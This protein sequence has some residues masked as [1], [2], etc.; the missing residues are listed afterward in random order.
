MNKIQVKSQFYQSQ[1]PIKKVSQRPQDSMIKEIILDSRP[2]QNQLPDICFCLAKYIVQHPSC[3]TVDYDQWLLRLMNGCSYKNVIRIIFRDPAIK[4][5]YNHL[6]LE[7]VFAP[8]YMTGLHL[9]QVDFR[10]RAVGKY[11]CFHVWAR[12]S[13]LPQRRHFSFDLPPEIQL[14][15][16]EYEI[17]DAEC[18]HFYNNSDEIIDESDYDS[19]LLRLANVKQKFQELREMKSKFPQLLAQTP[20]NRSTIRLMDEMTPPGTMERLL[21]APNWQ[22]WRDL[23]Q[24]LTTQR[25]CY[26]ASKESLAAS[27]LFSLN[28][29]LSQTSTRSDDT[30]DFKFR[31]YSGY[32]EVTPIHAVYQQPLE[33]MYELNFLKPEYVY[34][35]GDGT[36]LLTSA[37]CDEIDER[38]V[39]GRFLCRCH[40]NGILHFRGIMDAVFD[41]CQ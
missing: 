23:N 26:E 31:S 24:I 41:F 15:G 6:N 16:G 1:N 30:I 21:F 32:G 14:I 2:Y 34:G 25:I 12:T 13:K 8:T 4:I 35:D 17:V 27:M 28:D 20:P 19:K 39:D 18:L 3:L 22:S 40:H 36:V 29:P 7:E 33:N 10:Q 37:L 9:E 11:Q 38:F 5:D